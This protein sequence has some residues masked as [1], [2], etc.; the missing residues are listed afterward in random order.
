MQGFIYKHGQNRQGRTPANST[1]QGR[2]KRVIQY[3]GDGQGRQQNNQKTRKQ[4]N[5]Q[6]TGKLGNTGKVKS[7]TRNKEMAIQ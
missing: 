2:G 5:D 6:N 7:E 3:A 1:L 4:S